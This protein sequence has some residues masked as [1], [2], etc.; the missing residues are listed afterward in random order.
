MIWYIP[1]PPFFWDWE[2]FLSLNLS[3]VIFLIALFNMFA[4]G[5][6]VKKKK[7]K[8]VEIKNKP[9]LKRMRKESPHGGL[10]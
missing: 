2:L 5:T 6:V 3:R 8:A 10:H 1:C 7:K 9:S 4:A